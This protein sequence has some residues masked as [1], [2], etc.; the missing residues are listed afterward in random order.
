MF[1]ASIRCLPRRLGLPIALVAS[2]SAHSYELIT[3]G[4][5]IRDRAAPDVPATRSVPQPGAPSIE[6]LSPVV[7][8]PLTSPMDIKLRWMASAGSS[9]DVASARIKYGRLG[10]DVTNRVLGA[11]KVSPT[12]IDAPGAK[13]PPGTHRLAIEVADDQK[14]IGRR[15]FTVEISE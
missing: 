4:E 3:A 13:L 12:G 10:I 2:M 8:K 15:E 11:A 5:A 7:G 1:T 14:R 6:L 9:V